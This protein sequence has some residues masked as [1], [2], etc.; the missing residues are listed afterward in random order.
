MRKS[1]FAPI[2]LLFSVL[3]LYATLDTEKHEYGIER[4]LNIRSA[5]APA[6][7][8]DGRRIAFLTNI[9]GTS[10]VWMI[11]ADGGY[12]EQITAYE[13]RVSF[14]EWSPTGNGLVFGKGAGGNERTQFFW[15]SDD[16]ARV[17][18]LTDDPQ[19]RHNFGGFS[20]DGRRI[21]YSSN[22]RDR[23]YFDVYSMEIPDGKEKLIYQNDGSN[24]FAAASND[25]AKLIVS[26]S[27]VRFSRDNDLYLVDVK[28]GRAEHL[29]PHDEP[30][31][32]TDVEFLA[33][34]DIIFA[35]NEKSEFITLSLMDLATRRIIAQD[36]AGLGNLEDTALS[37]DGR[38]LASTN[39]AEGY[40]Q[41]YLRPLSAAGRA[42]IF[43]QTGGKSSTVV[44]V[45]LP[46]KGVAGSLDFSPDGK[47]IAFVFNSPKH[48][49]DIWTYDFADEKLTQITKSSTL[50]IPRESFIEPD[51][52]KYKT[53]D[54][55]EISAWYYLPK[56]AVQNA[57]I[58][59]NL[60]RLTN[61][62]KNGEESFAGKFIARVPVIVSVH[63]GPASQARPRFSSLYQY[64]LA[65]GYAIFVPNVRGS[66]GYGKS[67]SHLDDIEK[68]EDS[69]KDLAAGVE[70]LK[71]EGRTD[72]D[73]IA[74][75]GGSYG[76]YM[77]MAAITLYPEM[78]AAAVNT[79][80]I[81]NWET[82]LKNTSGYR[83]RQREVEYGFLDKNLDVL[84]SVSPIYRVDKIK[85]PLFVIHGK[86]DPRV[87]Y[88]EAEQLVEALR[89]RGVAVQYELFED[90]G[91]GI[92]KLEN[93]LEL[94]PKVADFLD[95]HLK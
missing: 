92:R 27:S 76:G 59:G 44:P 7:S 86:N 83:R 91:H 35:T 30:T 24:W 85:T 90:E 49:S 18:P 43:R 47:K 62:P 61:A 9:T 84:R 64:Y 93:R 34:G 4:Y 53:F 12:P 46:A 67:F 81:V 6:F 48:P 58:P 10:Q 32:Y 56:N 15:M 1:I 8:P 55:R 28:T 79:V 5:Y 65:R 14:V 16:G 80:G 88:T 42:G 40:T 21:Y 78:F 77:V 82:F 2:V 50:G 87:P 45:E 25:D 13:D 26:R 95:K 75:I 41:M 69:V 11:D 39:N 60:L 38:I 31:L 17:K 20:H 19:V 54:G 29:T 52:I 72:T 63:G 23:N 51:L 68:R 36:A 71:T 57:K 74:V 66:T 3:S 73:K 37:R 70:W 89:K 94:Y 22:K 33:N